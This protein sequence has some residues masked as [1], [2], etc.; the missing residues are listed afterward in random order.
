MQIHFTDLASLYPTTPKA[1]L[2][3]TVEPLNHAC[4]RFDITTAGRA[5]AFVAQIGHESMSFARMSENLNYSAEGLKAT[6]PKYFPTPDLRAAYARQP[7]RIANRVYANRMGNGNEASGDGWRY[8]GRGFIQLTG[9][10]NYDAFASYMEMTLPDVIAY[11]ETR[12]G[13]AMSA[14][15]Y[16]ASRGLNQYADQ[17]R[18]KELTIKINGGTHGY[19][20]RLAHYT[21]AKKLFG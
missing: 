9:R 8:R 21:K 3:A 10:V 7:Q 16:W 6:F 5:A 20:D 15:W 18:F 11:L 12:D 17:G 14:G 4:Q 19:D 13:A 1:I 2:E